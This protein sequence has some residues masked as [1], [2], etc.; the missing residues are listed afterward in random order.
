VWEL[1]WNIFLKYTRNKKKREIKKLKIRENLKIKTLEHKLINNR[2]RQCMH[3]VRV[4]KER[5]PK[6]VL[7]LRM[8]VKHI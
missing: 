2:R 5:I 6:K 1:S 4:N 8:K 3:V 7:N